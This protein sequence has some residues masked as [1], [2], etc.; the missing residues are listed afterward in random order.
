MGDIEVVLRK[1]GDEQS[2]LLDRFERLSFEVQL[3][4]AIMGRSLSSPS[5][6]R[7]GEPFIGLAPAPAP[8]PAP[9]PLVKH[10]QKGRRGSG[11][12]KALKKLLKPILG[13]MGSVKNSKKEV[14]DPRN[15]KSWKAFSRSLRV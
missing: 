14:P 2:T 1:F 5:G 8:S 7:F 6:G 9:S 13:R 12:H 15:P 10:V 4:Q 11:F 3:N